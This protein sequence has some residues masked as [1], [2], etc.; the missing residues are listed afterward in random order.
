MT[1]LFVR[2]IS[3]LI[4]KVPVRTASDNQV[5]FEA[6]MTS[7]LRTY[8]RHSSLPFEASSHPIIDTL[9]FSPAWINAFVVVTLVTI[10][11]LRPCVSKIQ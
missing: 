7:V 5:S 4:R 1:G 3:N 8:R 11:A 2:A 9:W 6:R 10:E